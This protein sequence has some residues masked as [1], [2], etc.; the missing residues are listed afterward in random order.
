MTSSKPNFFPKASPP[1]ATTLEIRT[2]TYEFGEGGEGGDTNIQFIKNE[3]KCH[4][5]DVDF[6]E[7]ITLEVFEAGNINISFK[8]PNVHFPDVFHLKRYSIKKISG[9]ISLGKTLKEI[10]EAS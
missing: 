9:P 2:S 6:A 8:Y 1:N 3:K 10:W 4:R 7:L 5:T